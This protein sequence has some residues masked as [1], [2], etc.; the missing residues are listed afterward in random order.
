MKDKEPTI[1]EQI[2]AN[3]MTRFQIT[4]VGVCIMINFLDGFDVIAIAFAAPEI[5]RDW[6]LAPT[7]LG[8]VFSSGLA[9]M[10]LGALF[11]SPFADRFGRRPLILLCLVIISAGMLASAAADSVGHLVTM[12]LLTGLGVGGMLASLTTMVAEYSS[13]RRRKLAISVL[14][15][16]YPVGGIIAGLSSAYLL[17]EFG[18]QSIFV[19]GGVLSLAMIP[20]VYWQLP[21]SMDFLLHQR[22][23]NALS[24]INKLLTRMKQTSLPE[25][26]ALTL[27]Q[28]PRAS[29]FRIFASDY[30]KQTFAIWICYVMVMSGWYFILN[31][32]PK[33][34][35]DAGMTRDAGISGGMLISI[36]GVLGGLALGWLSSWVRISWLGAGFML[37]SV[38]TMTVFGRLGVDLTAMLL[39]T[40]LIGF[41]LAAS[42]I[43]LYT[44][45]PDLYE[46]SIRNTGTGWALGI[47][48]LGAVVGPYV[49]G[50]LMGAG[51]DR[52]SY[53]FA[54]ALP[55]LVSAAVLLWLG[56]FMR[57]QQ[58]AGE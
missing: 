21:E 41:F 57:S 27:K 40:F 16:G 6:S 49:A 18:W 8:V 30:R 26:P 55:M 46:A 15:S 25:L 33:I 10:V 19:V 23:P 28:E 1:S 53:F 43:S 11:L 17:G 13:D 7:E 47:G 50:V 5:A 51:W 34:L 14:Q 48:R 29:V 9:G 22:G 38:L 20:V 37:C 24:R 45:L 31:W 42:M 32:T 52:P 2:H 35:V 3:D 4:A 36:G 44:I 54:L 58:Q 56:S 12:R 39:V